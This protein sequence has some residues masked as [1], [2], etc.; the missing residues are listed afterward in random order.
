M[1]IEV[2][3]FVL[4]GRNFVKG[5]HDLFLDIL[6]INKTDSRIGNLAE[7]SLLGA[8]FIRKKT[9]EYCTAKYI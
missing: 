9:L 8:V 1:W 7:L 5:K 3:I 4:N 6:T 2:K